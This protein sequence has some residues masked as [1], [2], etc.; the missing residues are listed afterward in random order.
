MQPLAPYKPGSYPPRGPFVQLG[1][2]QLSHSFQES[3]EI[4]KQN[5]DQKI[6]AAHGRRSEWRNHHMTKLKTDGHIPTHYIIADNDSQYDDATSTSNIYEMPRPDHLP[7]F[8]DSGSEMYGHAI[9]VPS[10]D[11]NELFEDSHGGELVKQETESE[12]NEQPS[13]LSMVGHAAVGA[14]KYMGNNLKNNLIGTAS[15]AKNT[16]VIGTQVVEVLAP[17]LQ[18]SAETYKKLASNTITVLE[19]AGPPVVY[20]SY[21]AANT[22][23]IWPSSLPRPRGQ[24]LTYCLLFIQPPQNP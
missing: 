22:A 10:D 19:I 12:T 6:L 8:P 15:L 1:D 21:L 16:A 5:L 2:A 11:D 14:A 4:V 3:D 18:K 23:L 13:M 9:P 24:L 7:P 17:E 20:G